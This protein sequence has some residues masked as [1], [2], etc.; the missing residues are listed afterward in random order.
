[1]RSINGV[2]LLQTIGSVIKALKAIEEDD[3]GKNR[4]SL[5]ERIKLYKILEENEAIINFL[6]QERPKGEDED[7]E[8]EEDILLPDEHPEDF[9]SLEELEQKIQAI[10]NH[11]DKKNIKPEDRRKLEKLYNLY[12][13][14][15]NILIENEKKKKKRRINKR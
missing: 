4:I 14:Q 8:A 6:T 2:Y 7:E 5:I 15:K 11:L 9:T 3:K 10:K 12:L 13:Q 1:M